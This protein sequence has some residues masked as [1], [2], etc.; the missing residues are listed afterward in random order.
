MSDALVTVTVATALLCALSAGAFF[1]FS[2]FVM[3]ALGRL[4]PG[5]GVAAMQAINVTAVTPAFM[6]VL[7][8]PGVAC[9]ALIVVGLANAGEPYAPWLLAG[10]VA[11]LVGTVVLTIA[12]HVPRN[13]TLAALRAGSPEAEA[14]WPRYLSQWTAAN[15]VRAAA[16][17]VAAAA[18]VVAALRSA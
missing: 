9:L 4:A 16:G 10:A 11:Y 12:Y 3:Q 5:A 7:F 2:S 18:L 13:D 6:T 14:Y 15:H 8:A 17:L 1:A